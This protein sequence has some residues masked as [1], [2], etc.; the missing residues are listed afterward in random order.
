VEKLSNDQ[1]EAIIFKVSEA[2]YERIYEDEWL[3]E[4][5]SEVNQELITSQQSD[6]ILGA[7]G[8]PQKYCGRS[9]KDAHP[10]IF[11]QEDMWSLR[12]QYLIE[13]LDEL[14]AP[15]W[16]KEKWLKIDNAFKLSILKKDVSECSGRFKT[17]PVINVPNPHKNKDSQL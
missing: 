8:G 6:F 12:Q 15:M 9:P 17:E 1:L 7:M 16:I 3:K 2:F 5:F 4:V 13:A 14:D 11:I 10:H